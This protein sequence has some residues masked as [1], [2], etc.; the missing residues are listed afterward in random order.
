NVKLTQGDPGDKEVGDGSAVS[1]L[2]VDR[3]DVSTRFSSREIDSLP[4][5]RQN[6]SQYELLV[7]GSVRT[8]AVLSTQQNP[9]GGVYA[10]LSGQHFSGTTV[11]VDGTVN[12]DPLQGIVVLNPS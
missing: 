7:P 11:I 12:R 8:I 9:Q 6:I 1:I 3:A 4:A 2:K 5:F 10:S